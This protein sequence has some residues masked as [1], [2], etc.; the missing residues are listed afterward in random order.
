[1]RFNTRSLF[2]ALLLLFAFNS[3]AQVDPVKG[4]TIFEQNCQSCHALDA[5]VIGP[6]LRGVE[7]L[8]ARTEKWLISWIKNNNKLRASGRSEPPHGGTRPR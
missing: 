7:K 4:K 6:A 5:K 1:M 8:P 3:N 2:M